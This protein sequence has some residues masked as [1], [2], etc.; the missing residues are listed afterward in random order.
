MG[1]RQDPAADTVI[2]TLE[3]SRDEGETWTTVFRGVYRREK[4]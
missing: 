3:R 1:Y 4:R 2:Q